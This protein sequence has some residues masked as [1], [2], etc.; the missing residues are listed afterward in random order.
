MARL[1]DDLGEALTQHGCSS[2]DVE[3]AR[4]L[5]RGFV[6]THGAKELSGTAASWWGALHYLVMVLSGRRITQKGRDPRKFVYLHDVFGRE[7]PFVLLRLGDAH[8]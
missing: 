8:G 4:A 3:G 1:A 7:E 6:E 5:W 2:A